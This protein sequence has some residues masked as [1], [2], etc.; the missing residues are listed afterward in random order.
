VSGSAT[1][2]QL[3]REVADGFWRV[4]AARVA[5]FVKPSEVNMT[6][7]GRVALASAMFAA[8]SACAS[9]TTPT[10]APSTDLPS[11]AAATVAGNEII[12]GR[13]FGSTGG[14]SGEVLTPLSGVT[15]D[16]VMLR[17]EGTAADTASAPITPV[18]IGA[19]RSDSQ[20]RFRLENVP[21]G[22]FALHATPASGSGYKRGTA[23][24][25]SFPRGSTDEALVYLYRH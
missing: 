21:S 12:Q 25:I 11:V 18:S 15:L 3:L 24:T 1:A 2:R 14:L 10:A 19:L 4:A 13:V 5:I 6:S 22:Q 23:Y 20:G 17:R 7:R 8:A 9:E 16:I